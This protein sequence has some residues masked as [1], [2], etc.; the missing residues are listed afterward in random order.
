[1]NATYKGFYNLNHDYSNAAMTLPD[2]RKDF[3]PAT[4]QVNQPVL[5][6]Y[7]TKD[8][9]VGPDHYVDISFPEMLLWKNEGGHI[10][11]QENKEALSEAILAYKA[12]YGF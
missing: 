7:G 4:A 2:Y 1:M 12:K 5:F 9:M 11:F 3:K 8:W 10:P 6:F